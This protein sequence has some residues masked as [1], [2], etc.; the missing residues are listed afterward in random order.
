MVPPA[1]VDV[2][3]VGAGFAG[4][5]AARELSRRDLSVVVLE[6]RDRVGGRAWT[7]ERWGM[8]LELGGTWIHPVQPH[9]WAEVMRYG[10]PMKRSPTAERCGWVVGDHC[11]FGDAAELDVLLRPCMDRMCELGAKL[12]PRPYEPLSA[13]D[14]LVSVDGRSVADEIDL[15]GLSEEAYV[16]ADGMWATNFSALMSEGALTQ[17]ARWCALAHGDWRLLFEAVAKL[18][19][20]NGTRELAS[21]IA[22]DGSAELQLAT[23]VTAVE[24]SALGVSVRTVSGSVESRAVVVAV[25]INTLADISFSPALNQGRSAMSLEKHAGHGSKVWVRVAGDM[26]PFFGYAT[27]AHPLTLVQYEGS[28]EG[29]SLLVG[30]GSD[31][32][33]FDG[34]DV[35][36]TARAISPWLPDA[37]VVAST[38]HNWTAD[39]FSLGT[40]GMLR[41]GQLT[42]YGADLYRQEPPL[43]F[44]GSD[45]AHGWA[46]FIDGAIESGLHTAQAVLD[47]L[48]G[49]VVLGR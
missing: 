19:L 47:Y 33:G 13:M 28:V 25:P 2:A 29:D 15:L 39:P 26:A 4:L 36:A 12:Y 7:D 8:A 40:W 3:I 46:G 42:A 37:K 24:T 30:F 17:A 49:E 20:K 21:R 10:L 1:Q 38:S 23:R 6:A 16:V 5:T 41:P 34:N 9:V 32:L 43:F 35:D 11:E 45:I 14:A 44:A 31:G 48:R 18:K 27:T 22:A